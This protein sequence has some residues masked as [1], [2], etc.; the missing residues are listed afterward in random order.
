VS[1]VPANAEP[2]LC[3]AYREEAEL[4]R[5]ALAAGS[6]V[7]AALQRGERAEEPL[8]RLLRLLDRA[9]AIE[10]RVAPIR[11]QCQNAGW[12]PGPPLDGMIGEVRHLIERLQACI[13]EAERVAHQRK[14]ELEPQLDAVI[15]GS[16]MQ[17]AYGN[18]R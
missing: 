5:Q 9:G 15:R 16:Q 13:Q 7:L 2:L 4:Y 14:S 6:D 12:K 17:R 11:A 3:D 8:R 18:W 10:A 1:A